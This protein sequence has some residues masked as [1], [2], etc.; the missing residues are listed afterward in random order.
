MNQCIICFE[1]SNKNI[2]KCYYCKNCMDN[3]CY[4]L[5]KYHNKYDILIK[6]PICK[7]YID[8]HINNII[9]K[10]SDFSVFFVKNLLIE[11]QY[12]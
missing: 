8:I 4:K 11:Y 12:D 3:D 5:Y 6:C 1:D 9:K 7:L 10:I 2:I